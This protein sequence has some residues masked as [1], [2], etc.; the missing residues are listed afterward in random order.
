M[1]F[2]KRIRKGKSYLSDAGKYQGDR[3]DYRMRYYFDETTLFVTGSFRV[4]SASEPGKICSV[5]TVLL[6]SHTPLPS[7]RFLQKELESV[8][9]RAGM[10]SDFIGLLTPGSLPKI[11]I[12]KYD[13]VSVFLAA[14]TIPANHAGK[15]PQRWLS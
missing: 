8:A 10:G 1:L 9:A 6:H 15:G 3:V 14:V 7:D 12:L 5:S 2:A 11:C 13:F 4:A